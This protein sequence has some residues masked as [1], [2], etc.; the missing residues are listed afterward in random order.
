MTGA[1]IPTFSVIIPTWNDAA[2]VGR[3]VASVLAQRFADFELIVVDD[4]ST[5]DT[6]ERLAAWAD[7]RL[8]YLR[9]E[10]GGVTRARNHGIR[11]S[12]GRH[13]TFLD[14][15]D[16]VEPDWLASYAEAFADPR[17]EVVCSGL[18]V[19][20]DGHTEPLI[21]LPEPGD[22]LFEHREV[23]FLA[24]TFAARRELVE[25]VGGYAEGLPFAEN[26]ELGIRLVAQ[27][28]EGGGDV[29]S[30]PRP[31]TRYFPRHHEVPDRARERQEQRLVGIT[32]LLELHGE[33]F[34]RHPDL[35]ESH[36]TLAG[37][38]AVRAGRPREARRFFA[39]AIHFNPGNVKG[40]GRLLLSLVPGLRS[41]IW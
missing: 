6:G 10:H 41:R 4:G 5:D 20:L 22:G 38:T 25:R 9:Q 30:I 40:Y 12:R 32:Q 34:R 16:Q 14:S 35:Y 3:A 23:L 15:D 2:V 8:R 27:C 29:R 11:S 1:G 26:T 28:L 39:R 21:K 17:V 37:V 7:P 36:L 19:Y 18:A 13:L 33:R 31:L 24:G